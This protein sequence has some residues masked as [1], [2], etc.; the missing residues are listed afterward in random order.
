MLM[1]RNQSVKVGVS[2]HIDNKVNT[3]PTNEAQEVLCNGNFKLSGVRKGGS[4]R[5]LICNPYYFNSWE[6]GQEFKKGNA[7][8]SCS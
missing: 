3:R 5:I 2:R 4:E 1:C 8:I 7:P 6:V